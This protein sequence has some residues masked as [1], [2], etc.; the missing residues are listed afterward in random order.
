MDLNNIWVIVDLLSCIHFAKKDFK[1]I[2][3]REPNYL[4]TDPEVEK[5]MNEKK[6]EKP[7]LFSFTALRTVSS[8]MVY[9][10]IQKEAMSE[11]MC[12]DVC[13]F[14]MNWKLDVLIV[15]NYRPSSTS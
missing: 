9:Y 3:T 8:T 11:I 10:S 1:I 12:L 13:Y 4:I 14:L 2:N 15:C 7:E 5:K 6:E